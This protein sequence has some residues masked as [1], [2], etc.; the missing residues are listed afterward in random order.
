MKDVIKVTVEVNDLKD[1]N[2]ASV[3]VA[4]DE[5]ILQHA[6][7]TGKLNVCRR[8]AECIPELRNALGR[9]IEEKFFSS[10]KTTKE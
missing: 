1:L 7:K 6:L 3:T 9:L 10:S 8:V 2:K 4:M 5:E